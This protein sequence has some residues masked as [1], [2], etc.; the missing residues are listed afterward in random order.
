[1]GSRDYA[2][3]FARPEQWSVARSGIDVFKFHT[4]N[5][6]EYPCAIC[7]ENTLSTFVDVQAFQKLA[8]WGM[9][10]G[11]DVGA[12][13]EWGCTGTEEF[14]VVKEIIH[15]IAANGGRV[16]LL[17]MDEPYMGGELV[18]N[19]KTCGFT[20]EQSADITAKFIGLVEAAY[21]NIIVGDT[22]PY[23]YFSVSELELWIGALEARGA[24]P[25]FFHLDVNM[26][27]GGR[28]LDKRRVVSDLQTLSRFFQ[29]H[30]IPWG[31]IFTANSKWDASS[32]LAYFDSTMEWIGL[33]NEAI[34]KPQHVV[35]N[36]WLGPTTDGVSNRL[37][38]HEL[39]VNLPEDDPSVYSHTRLIIEGLG[40]FG[41]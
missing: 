27:E 5:V 36:S 1:M 4:Q 37:G 2:E 31:V 9:P 32:D 14:R 23:P 39:P 29:E 30:Q 35:F 16:A 24:A 18:A 33:V 41:P 13:K 3:L 28:R 21:P 17:V 38:V 26:M 11:V 6:L 25:A 22:E 15:N 7:G 10:I 40:L 19:G 8:E 34:G 20:M 12:V